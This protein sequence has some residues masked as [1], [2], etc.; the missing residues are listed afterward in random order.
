MGSRFSVLRSSAV[1]NGEDIS[2]T[3]YSVLE[4]GGHGRRPKLPPEPQTDMTTKKIVMTP[5]EFELPVQSLFTTC[6]SRTASTQTGDRLSDCQIE[7]LDICRVGMR[8]ILRFIERLLQSSGRADNRSTFHSR[9]AVFPPSLNHLG[10]DASNTSSLPFFKMTLCAVDR[11]AHHA[12]PYLRR[13]YSDSD[14]CG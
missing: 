12:R 3:T 8:R 6:M 9:N 10:V 7:A 11:F 2:E 1:N 4:T 5:R 14:G 13:S